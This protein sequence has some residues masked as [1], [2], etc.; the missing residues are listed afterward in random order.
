MLLRTLMMI[1]CHHSAWYCTSTLFPVSHQLG[2]PLSLMREEVR[3]PTTGSFSKSELSRAAAISRRR[4]RARRS[5]SASRSCFRSSSSLRDFSSIASRSR[6]R[7][8]RSFSFL[9][10]SESARRRASS[11][12][13]RAADSASSLTRCSWCTSL[14]TMRLERLRGISSNIACFDLARSAACALERSFGAS[15]STSHCANSRSSG[16][17]CFRPSVISFFPTSASSS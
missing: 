15:S 12:D 14:S 7:S 1:A 10:F 2:S 16:F 3:T 4:F 5:R 9:R 11:S 17:L 8:S 6:R 13:F